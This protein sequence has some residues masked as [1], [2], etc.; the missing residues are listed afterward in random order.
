VPDSTRT[1]GRENLL[2]ALAAE[3]EA[4]IAHAAREHALLLAGLRIRITRHDHPEHGP[5]VAEATA[6]ADG[7]PIRVQV[8]ATDLDTLIDALVERTIA[9]LLALTAPWQPRPAQDPTRA[10]LL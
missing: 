10:R 9:R 7:R 2:F 4:S 8:A 3:A 5:A 6:H 1:T